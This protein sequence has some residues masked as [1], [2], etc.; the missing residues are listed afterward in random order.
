MRKTDLVLG[1]VVLC[2]AAS[3]T[4]AQGG[5]AGWPVKDAAIASN[6]KLVKALGLQV[7]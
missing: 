7:D 5:S 3:P 6:V 2:M 1:A 4:S